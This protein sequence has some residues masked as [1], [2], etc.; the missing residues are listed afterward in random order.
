VP[1]KPLR[2]QVFPL[3]IQRNNYGNLLDAQPALDFF[4]SLNGIMNIFEALKVY[5]PSLY[6]DAKKDPTPNLY[7]LT[8]RTRFP[9]IP[10]Y[11][12]FE[13]FVMM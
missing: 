5:E 10:V 9:V 13:R 3:W 11:S 8:L 2:S 4:F 7:S 12:V 1:L 6:F